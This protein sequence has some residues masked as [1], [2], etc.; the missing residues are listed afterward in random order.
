MIA[1]GRGGPLEGFAPVSLAD[2]NG[3]AA[4]QRR[5]DRKYVVAG[6]VLE[7][8][9][10]GLPRAT[11]V[12]EIDGARLFTYRTMYF[13]SPDL[14]TYRAHVQGRR[15]R[16][17]CRSRLYVNSNVHML[18]VKLKGR[19]GETVKERRELPLDEHGV[20]GAAASRFLREQLLRHYGVSLDEQLGPTVQMTFS[21]LTLV[22]LAA[23]KRMTVDTGLRYQLADGSS[24][25]LAPGTA[26]VES[27]S[28]SGSAGI[29]RRA[30][31]LGVRPVNCS[32]YCVGVALTRPDAA[33]GNDFLRLAR[34]H[35]DRESGALH[36]IPAPGV[37]A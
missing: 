23:G 5:I 32:K 6:P 10:A 34:R 1:D 14:L 9:I 35:F 27:K 11:A 28:A 2:L 12:L 13:D 19:R 36:A 16:F 22:D 15:R 29:D 26:I 25:A 24:F 18:E 17:K 4:L 33:R 7:A 31:E 20:W 3:R 30:R 37:A 8:L 21:R